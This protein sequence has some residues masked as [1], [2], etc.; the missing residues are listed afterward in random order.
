MDLEILGTENLMLSIIGKKPFYIRPPHGTF[1]GLIAKALAPY[2]YKYVIKW[3]L[4]I[5]GITF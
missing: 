3:N 4:D 2:D 1:N 5:K